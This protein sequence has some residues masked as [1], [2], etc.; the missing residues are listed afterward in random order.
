MV[1]KTY[2]LFAPMHY[3][4]AISQTPSKTP[5]FVVSKIPNLEN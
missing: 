2:E 4:F 1:Q 3:G 5:K